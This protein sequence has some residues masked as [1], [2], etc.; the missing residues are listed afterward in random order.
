WVGP[1]VAG[2]RILRP[3]L[4]R[5][6]RSELVMPAKAETQ[7]GSRAALR[8][9]ALFRAIDVDATIGSSVRRVYA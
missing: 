4:A 8:R 9:A 2:R 5:S 1:A 6:R 3:A 7:R